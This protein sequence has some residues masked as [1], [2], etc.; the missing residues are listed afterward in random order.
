MIFN[1]I[2]KE[3]F[4]GM[5]L[6][7]CIVGG[8]TMIPNLPDTIAAESV[9]TQEIAQCLNSELVTWGDGI[10]RPAISSTL[11]FA[12]NHTDAP[13]LFTKFQVAEMI[14]KSAVAWSQCGVPSGMIDLDSI[15]GQHGDVIRVQ[16]SDKNSGGNFGLA[17]I[18][19][20]TLSL[21][22]KAFELLKTRNPAYDSR[23]TLQMVISH[24][25]G[26]FFGLMAHSRRCVDVLS[27]Y[28]NGKGDTCYS[29][30]PA[31]MRAVT[32]YRYTLP[33]ACDIQ[34]CRLKNGM[35]PLPDGRLPEHSQAK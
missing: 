20:R 32:E 12:Y 13:G 11:K 24:E 33:T 22:P 17:N 30:D 3:K 28:D 7:F 19:R 25:M 34:R 10:D 18:G 2:Y 6:F 21:G 23:E 4:R 29:R 26:H 5:R 35:P 9:R 27:Y 1:F 8:L 16:W 14:T 31:G 15:K